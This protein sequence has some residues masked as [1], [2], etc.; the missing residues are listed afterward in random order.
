MNVAEAIRHLISIR[1]NPKYDVPVNEFEALGVAIAVCGSLS[2]QRIKV[3][4][5]ILQYAKFSKP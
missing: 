1:D 3:I 4:D 2:D 5:H